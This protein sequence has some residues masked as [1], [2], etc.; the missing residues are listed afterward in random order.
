[1]FSEDVEWPLPIRLGIAGFMLIVL[2]LAVVVPNPSLRPAVRLV[3]GLMLLLVF[4]IIWIFSTL[5][6][7][8]DGTQLM[9]GFGPFRTY[10]ARS[11]I[12]SAEP[13]DY[14]WRDWG[15]FG[16]RIRRGARLYNVIG[17]RGQ[18]V[19]I[20]LDDGQQIFFS[21]HDPEAVCRALDLS[22]SFYS[23]GA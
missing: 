18:A 17:D 21:S 12:V 2:M 4:T 15:G 3:L 19:Q 22:S 20:V 1:M 13:V 9:L 7:R 6:I 8:I 23:D 10:I 11:R 16:L 14:R 5:H